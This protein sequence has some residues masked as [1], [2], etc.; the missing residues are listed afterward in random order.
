MKPKLEI[1]AK[2]PCYQRYYDYAFTMVVEDD[3]INNPP[4]KGNI[5]ICSATQDTVTPYFVDKAFEVPQNCRF[6]LEQTL[7][8][9]APA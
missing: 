2:C 6:I 3:F 4:S 5:Y 9:E 7:A 8:T 1:C